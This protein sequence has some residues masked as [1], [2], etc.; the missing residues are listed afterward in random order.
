M[1]PAVTVPLDGLTVTEETGTGLTVTVAL[2]LLPSLVAV[3]A[4]EPT[5]TP[6][7][8]P[9]ELTVAMLALPVLQLTTRPLRMFPAASRIVAE[10]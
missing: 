6:V 1:L 3:T 10:S 4:A 8:R 2:E 5:P 9:L 7:T